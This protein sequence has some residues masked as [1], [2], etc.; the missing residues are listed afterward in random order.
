[1]YIKLANIYF[2]P[3]NSLILNVKEG[4]MFAENLGLNSKKNKKFNK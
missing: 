1:M 4:E 3:R 2:F